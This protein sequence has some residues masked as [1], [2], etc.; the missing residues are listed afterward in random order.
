MRRFGYWGLGWLGLAIAALVWQAWASLGKSPVFPG[1]FTSASDVV[2][3]VNGPVLTQD[4]LPSV[5]RVLV[6]FAISAVLGIAVGLITGYYRSAREWTG[7]VFA[8]FRSLPTPLLIPVALVLFG[9]GG[10]MVIAVIVTAAVWPVLINT[11]NAV[12]ALEP[13]LLD[14]ARS[15]GLRGPALLTKVVLPA[16][17]PQIFAGLRVAISVSL[18]VL[19]V[20]EILGG[21]SGI[22]Y[23][24]E[25]AQQSFRITDSYAGVIILCLLGWAADTSFLLLERRLLS[26][27]R[28]MVGGER[29][30]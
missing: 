28:G 1:F 8:F 3:I 17:S 11:T 27:Q 15:L 5:V 4:L 2:N 10:T 30:A 29:L 24:I 7:A 21:A 13:T 26:W 12:A 16:V 14:T 23:F 9:L 25:S 22:G 19:V 6:G 18:A 20:A